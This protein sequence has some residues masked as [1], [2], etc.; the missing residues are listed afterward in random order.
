MLEMITTWD[1]GNYPDLY[2]PYS[3]CISTQWCYRDGK[4]V[5]LPWSF[6]VPGDL[7]ILLP[8]QKI[9][10]KCHLFDVMSNFAFYG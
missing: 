3:P 1:D 4:L 2:M 7:V 6:L 5:N 8:G 9:I 10:A